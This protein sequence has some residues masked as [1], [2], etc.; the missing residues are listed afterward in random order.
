[1]L[2][3]HLE[4]F[5]RQR[6]DLLRMLAQWSP[7]QLRSRPQPDAWCALDVVEH[8][9]LVEEAMLVSMR[10]NRKGGEIPSVRDRVRGWLVLGVMALPTRVKVPAGAQH[11]RPSGD[12]GELADL[13]DRWLE[14][15]EKLGAFFA[16]PL[17]L[18]RGLVQHPVVGSMTP[19]TTLRFLRSHLH[20]HGYQLRRMRTA[21][22]R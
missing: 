11:V 22:S 18:N 6:E 2:D 19:V 12:V 8:L 13:G 15:R 3:R 16:Q 7:E 9:I 20:H 10:R 17:P 14:V 21:A 4:S 1:M 5:E